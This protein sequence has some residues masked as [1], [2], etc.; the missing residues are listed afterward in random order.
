MQLCCKH[1]DREFMMLKVRVEKKIGDLN[2]NAGFAIEKPVITALLGKSGA[3]KTTLANMLSGL[4]KP[5]RG[6]VVFNDSVFFDGE[7]HVDLPPEQRGIGYVFQEHRLFPHL[8]VRHNLTFGCWAGG[9]KNSEKLSKIVE[10]LELGKLLERR[11][12][13]LSGGESQRVAIGRAL[14][15]CTSFLI[16]D[17]PLSSLD[18]ALKENIM[19]Y[20]AMIPMNFSFPMIYITHDQKEVDRLAEETLVLKGGCL[21]GAA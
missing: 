21:G 15:A 8:S 6:S 7:R 3:G 13:T 12:D 1:I 16:M 10:L 20:I 14:Y 18:A 17:E 9:R 2:I 19:D 5:D 4:V 11:P